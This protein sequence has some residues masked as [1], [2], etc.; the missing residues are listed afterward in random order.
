MII[1]K[2]LKENS[3]RN[4]ELTYFLASFMIC[5]CQHDKSDH[6]KEGCVIAGCGCRNFSVKKKLEQGKIDDTVN[7][8]T[9][10]NIDARKLFSKYDKPAEKSDETVAR[11][12][13]VRDSVTQTFTEISQLGRDYQEKIIE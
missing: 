8:I 7:A 2:N 1:Y 5:H 13:D 4:K 3:I 11:R 9:G 6:E 10:F 12:S